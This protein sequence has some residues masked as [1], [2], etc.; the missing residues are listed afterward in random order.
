[1]N[2]EGGTLLI[3]VTDDGNVNGIEDDINSLKRKDRDGFEQHLIQVLSSKYLNPEFG[4]YYRVSIEPIDDKTICAVKVDRSPKAVFL[5]D[6]QTSEFYVRTGNTT[7]PLDAQ[8][9]FEYI[10]MH[11]EAQ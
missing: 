11:W 1:M 4:A 3:G 5:K 9:Q 6:N 8:A 2:S 10:G 7:R